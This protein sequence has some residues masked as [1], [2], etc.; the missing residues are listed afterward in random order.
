MIDCRCELVIWR[1]NTWAHQWC[2]PLDTR[3]MGTIVWGKVGQGWQRTHR[4]ASSREAAAQFI[5]FSQRRFV[6]RIVTGHVC[7]VRC[8]PAHFI[9]LA[10]TT[11]SKLRG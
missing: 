3:N 11:L 2:G 10:L 8:N 4:E 1:R 5:L 6:E 7:E 9:F